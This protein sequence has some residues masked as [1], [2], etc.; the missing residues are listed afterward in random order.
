MEVY[1][2]A[3]RICVVNDGGEAQCVCVNACE[4]EEDAR[5]RVS[6]TKYTHLLVFRETVG[7]SIM[8]T[9]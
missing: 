9:V 1:C 4:N 6:F 3:G 7:C 8:V 2:G 5:R